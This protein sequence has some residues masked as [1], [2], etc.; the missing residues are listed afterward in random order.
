[1]NIWDTI[2]LDKTAKI[3]ALLRSETAKHELYQKQR[4]NITY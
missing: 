4:T 3:L 1:M 2:L